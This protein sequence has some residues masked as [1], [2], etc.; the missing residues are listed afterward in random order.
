[1]RNRLDVVWNGKR[2][3]ARFPGYL[4]R[5]AMAANQKS[6]SDMCWEVRE[7]LSKATGT[8]PA[9]EKWSASDMV[10]DYLVREV[11]YGLLY[12]GFNSGPDNA[13]SCYNDA[14]S[15]PSR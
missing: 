15:P 9:L 4:W 14:K 6:D 11:D 5:F 3:T 2:T 12:I 1:M 8:D 13:R 10:R 7:F